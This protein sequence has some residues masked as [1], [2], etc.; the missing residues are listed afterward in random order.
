M[1]MPRHKIEDYRDLRH[2]IE[3]IIDDG[4]ITINLLNQKYEINE[5]SKA[6]YASHFN[7]LSTLILILLLYE[8]MDQAIVK[9]KAHRIRILI[10]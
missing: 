2:K 4:G 1:H 10:H 7:P 6:H 9:P 8:T 5:K 3:N